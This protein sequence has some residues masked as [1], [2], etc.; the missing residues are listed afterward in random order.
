MESKEPS[1]KGNGVEQDKPVGTTEPPKK[2]EDAKPK[3]EIGKDNAAIKDAKKICDDAIREVDAIADEFTKAVKSNPDSL[4]DA[5]NFVEKLR[6]VLDRAKAETRAIK[7]NTSE[8]AEKYT[9]YGWKSTTT[10][11]RRWTKQ[12][13]FLQT[14]IHGNPI[15]QSTT[16]RW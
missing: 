5:S 10:F 14:F 2:S 6:A 9:K 15:S 8:T 11:C 12:I 13:N 3:D 16:F 4:P 1:K 7:T